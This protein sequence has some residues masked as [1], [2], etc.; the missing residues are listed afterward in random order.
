LSTGSGSLSVVLDPARFLEDA[1]VPADLT[2]G[3]AGALAQV[4]Q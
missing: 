4:G 2:F 3:Y 1:K